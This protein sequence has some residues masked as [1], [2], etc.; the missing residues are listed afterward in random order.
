[1]KTKIVLLAFLSLFA[2]SCVTQRRC[3][4]KFPPTTTID[5]VYIEK[6]KEVPVYIPG[7]TIN[8]IAPVNCPDQDVASIENSKLK[9]Q[10]KIL[11]GKLISN[12]TIKPDTIKVTVTE[13]VTKIKEVITL[14]PVKFIPKIYKSALI[15]CIVIF[16]GVFAWFG[17]KVYKMFKPKI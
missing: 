3:I 13:T 7:D 15:I 9:Q 6:V 17:I 12:T 16:A 8:I 11:N 5:S 14:Q 4:T 1:M 10:I 2:L